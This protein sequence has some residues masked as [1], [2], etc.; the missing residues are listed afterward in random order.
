MKR[1]LL[2]SEEIRHRGQ[3]NRLPLLRHHDSATTLAQPLVG[4]GHNGNL[5]DGGM[6]VEK[7][8]DL[9]DRNILAAANDH[10][11]R[12]AGD[13]DVALIIDLG[14]VAGVEPS[15]GIRIV[16]MGAA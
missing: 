16:Q 14:E 15:L 11:L 3:I 10:V 12:P 1:D 5:A 13:P 4:I 8:L 2:R 6:L 7:R 9:H